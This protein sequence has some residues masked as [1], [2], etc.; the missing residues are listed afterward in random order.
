MTPEESIWSLFGLPHCPVIGKHLGRGTF[1]HFPDWST[2][3]LAPYDAVMQIEQLFLETFGIYKSR[4]L[5]FGDGLQVIY[6]PNESGKTTL[7]AALR[8]TLFGM[9]HQSHYAFDGTTTTQARVRLADGRKISLTRKK[10]RGP[11]L[12]GEFDESREP[13]TPEL[14]ERC[15]TGATAGL[16]ENV[17]AISLGELSSGEKSLQSAGLTEALF[18]MAIGGMARF[19]ELDN[20]LQNQCELLFNSSGNAKKPRVNALCLDLQ[21]AAKRYDEARFSARDYTGFQE[22]IEE[23]EALAQRLHVDRDLCH[24]RD[25]QLERVGAALTAW[26][27]AER[28]RN[29]W[30]VLGAIREV[31]LTTLGELRAV[32]SSLAEKQAELIQLAERMA[33]PLAEAPL[34]GAELLPHEAPIRSLADQVARVRE[35]LVEQDTLS[36][37]LVELEQRIAH[38]MT[39]IQPGWTA[40]DLHRVTASLAQRETAQLLNEESAR[41]QQSVESLRSRRSELQERRSQIEV[42]LQVLPETDRIEELRDLLERAK[43]YRVEAKRYR[44]VAPELERLVAQRQQQAAQ[45]AHVVG[46]S[47]EALGALVVPLDSTVE[48]Y[49][50]QV[51]LISRN[52]EQSR[53]RREDAELLSAESKEALARFDRDHEVCDRSE[54]VQRRA[55]REAGLELIVCHF[56]EGES[57]LAAIQAWTKRQPGRLIDLYRE[58]VAAADLLADKLLTNAA[59]MGQR[60]QLVYRSEQCEVTWAERVAEHR[61]ISG[62]F[63]TLEQEWQAEWPPAPFRTRTPREMAEWLKLRSQW[64]DDRKTRDQQ[65]AE[66]SQRAAAIE[67]FEAELLLA[68]PKPSTAKKQ[69]AL[70]RA[71][72]VAATELERVLTESMQ[73]RE[74]L[75]KEQSKVFTKCEALD[76]EQSELALVGV[77][78]EA[79]KA[80]FLDQLGLPGDWNLSVA[81]RVVA[82]LMEVQSLDQKRITSQLRWQQVQH[83]IESFTEQAQPL[84]IGLEQTWSDSRQ[85][86]EQILEWRSTLDE[87]RRIE[88]EQTRLL[89]ERSTSEKLIGRL[90]EQITELDARIESLRLGLPELADLGLPELLD[91][92]DRAESLR[93]ELRELD[94]QWQVF[95]DGDTEFGEQLRTAKLDEVQE[96]RQRLA[97]QMH[98]LDEER[99]RE[100]ASAETVRRSLQAREQET[101]ALERGQ[102]LESLRAQLGDAVD[103]WVP[104]A[105]AR[106]LMEAAR[107]RFEKT[108]QPQLLVEAGRIFEQ[109][110]LGEYVQLTRSVGNTTELQAIPKTGLAKSPAEMSTGTREQLYLAIR[111][112][113]LKQYS[114]RAEPLPLVMDDVLVNFDE[115][116]AKQTLRVLNDFSQSHQILFLT[117]HRR[118][119]ELVQS[120]RPE[121]TPIELKPGSAER[122]ESSERVIVVEPPTSKPKRA[123]RKP[124]R[125]PDEMEQQPK[126]AQ[127]ALFGEET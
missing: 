83:Q 122:V 28:V 51:D 47:V 13:L 12:T 78:L 111:L 127:P 124:A 36:K 84:L 126:S 59:E 91:A 104:L 97:Q 74:R 54:L 14:W 23:H 35:A 119:V 69:D 33:S 116:R 43:D 75:T 42:E 93:A 108:Q 3:A 30:S 110:T 21:A 27:E 109:L 67:Q 37:S 113:Y 5:E 89:S 99:T 71:A 53:L 60:Q 92:A 2:G 39:T 80:A 73:S 102:Q 17:F 10:T 105:L 70:V 25:R 62:E 94:H 26:R 34:L 18:G 11:G 20:T 82:R 45:L 61:R 103:Q 79:R 19:R 4:R 68:F 57:D 58:R 72:L 98:E 95:A 64:L 7:L 49:V 120:I 63:A 125:G 123:A 6:G 118:M 48:R 100:R 31:P 15:L 46:V 112:A 117:C 96:E 32:S 8:Q 44:E 50:A 16:F 52:L 56:V 87:R 40:A 88:L 115:D 101:L 65:L 114:Q 41:Q 86:C 29:E 55:D 66:Q 22:Q 81:A 38:E 90:R 121:L 1:G 9:P 106:H 107:V 77:D 76:R 85:A 24:K